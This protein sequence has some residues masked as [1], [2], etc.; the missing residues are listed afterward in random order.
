MA[1]EIAEKI[2]LLELPDPSSNAYLLGRNILVD[3]GFSTEK[4]LESEL[5]EAGTALYEVETIF[6]TH[7]HADHSSNARFIPQ[8]TVC[9]HPKAVERLK[10]KELR[11]TAFNMFGVEAL[12][13]EKFEE[14][15]EGCKMSIERSSMAQT[16]AKTPMLTESG[17]FSLQTLFTPGHTDD[18]VCFYESKTK[19]LFCGDT[20]FVGGVPRIFGGGSREALLGSWEKIGEKCAG[21]RLVCTGH[22]PLSEN[23]SKE[24]EYSRRTL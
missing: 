6:L 2:F 23:L 20:L 24:L 4:Q 12:P 22:G 5:E 1:R 19:T 16:S 15:S 3:P 21:A 11:E 17:A 14:L 9:A 8:A 18:A 13:N 7:S 10:G